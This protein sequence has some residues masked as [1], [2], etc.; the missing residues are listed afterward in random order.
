MSGEG[1]R[2]VGPG[3][4]CLK[5]HVNFLSFFPLF[6]PLICLNFHKHHHMS[7]SSMKSS[8]AD[9]CLVLFKSKNTH[10]AT[11][12]TSNT[13]ASM[14]SPILAKS[15]IVHMV[16]SSFEVSPSDGVSCNREW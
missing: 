11:G 2:E 5:I 13:I 4:N 14:P 16:V 12:Y 10:S 15:Y 1:G 9:S 6:P 8:I 7:S 3:T